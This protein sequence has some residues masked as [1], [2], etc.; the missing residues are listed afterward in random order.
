MATIERAFSNL[1]YPEFGLSIFKKLLKSVIYSS[2][3]FIKFW[4]I[5]HVI[6]IFLQRILNQNY[7]LILSQFFLNHN[8]TC[9]GEV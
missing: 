6:L 4:D 2:L 8:G 9:L 5:L 3:T 7:T 1:S